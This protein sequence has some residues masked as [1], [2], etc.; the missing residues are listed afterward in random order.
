MK[1]LVSFGVLIGSLALW[2]AWIEGRFT[3]A[4]CGRKADRKNMSGQ[5]TE[6]ATPP[7]KKR[8]GTREGDGVRSRGVALSDGDAGGRSDAGCNVTR[9]FRELG[10]GLYRKPAFGRN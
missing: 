8:K 5:A 2:P 6:Q 7:A 3:A 9:I 4:R 10:Q 1:T